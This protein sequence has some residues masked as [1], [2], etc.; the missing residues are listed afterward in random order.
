[1]TNGH[2]HPP[3]CCCPTTRY[4]GHHIAWQ[5]EHS[6]GQVHTHPAEAECR[7]PYC[8]SCVEHGDLAN[9]DS[10]AAALAAHRCISCHTPDDQPHTDYCQLANWAGHRD[11]CALQWTDRCDCLD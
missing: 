7:E 1:M 4:T 10:S 6:D 2:N 9:L 11:N 5:H 3:H 8:P